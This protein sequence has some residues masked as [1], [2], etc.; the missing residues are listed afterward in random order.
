[1]RASDQ[2][3][4]AAFVQEIGRESDR[5]LALVGAAFI[6]EKLADV[7]AAFLRQ[8]A[9]GLLRGKNAPLGAFSAR[10]EMCHALGLIEDI[11]RHECDYIR[12]I[13]NEFAHRVTGASFAE[14][15]V[16]D[17]CSNLRSAMPEP[18]YPRGATSRFEFQNAVITMG[19]RLFY[20]AEYVEKERR[21]PK[22]WVDPDQ[23]RWRR[24]AEERPPE[25]QAVIAVAFR[26]GDALKP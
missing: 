5:G 22:Q 25:N 2:K 26:P 3:A 24:I 11:E 17:L 8:G 6:D 19:S 7:L 1:M 4:F 12:K 21:T 10:I 13:R 16:R 18:D 9:A 23:V 15:K 14:G 20:R